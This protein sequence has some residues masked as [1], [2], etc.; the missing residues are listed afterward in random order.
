[1]M[2]GNLQFNISQFAVGRGA[3]V[4]ILGHLD[5]VSNQRF[6][7]LV[8]PS[9]DK[10]LVLDIRQVL[11]GHA[12]LMNPRLFL[13]RWP[14][15]MTSKQCLL[16][17]IPGVLE[18]STVKCVSESVT[19]LVHEGGNGIKKMCRLGLS[20]W[21]CAELSLNHDIYH[22]RL[23]PRSCLLDSAGSLKVSDFL[24]G[25]DP[26]ELALFLNY[27]ITSMKLKSCIEVF[28]CRN[29]LNNDSDAASQVQTYALLIWHLF[30][31]CQFRNHI[32]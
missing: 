20:S 22:R 24:T 13:R 11:P 4:G 7:V 5:N 9:S 23:N 25:N 16:C 28:A 12:M 17:F 14:M 1:M 19:L 10:V 30:S 29:M 18:S 15:W 27:K 31:H 2:N 8:F 32:I 21:E 6:V 3:A 26:N